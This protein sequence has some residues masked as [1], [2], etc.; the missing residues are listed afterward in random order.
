[1]A[2]VTFTLAIFYTVAAIPC[3]ASDKVL[4]AEPPSSLGL[5]NLSFFR[6]LGLDAAMGDALLEAALAM[7]VFAAA[8][9]VMNSYRKRN[10][11]NTRAKGKVASNEPLTPDKL[12][13]RSTRAVPHS[14]TESVQEDAQPSPVRPAPKPCSVD[15]KSMKPLQREADALATAVRQGKVTQLPQLLDSAIDR[16]FGF[17]ARQDSP[18]SK[19]EL[20]TALLHASLR[21]CAANRLFKEGIATYEHVGQRIGEGSSGLWS[22]LLYCI[23]EAGSFSR[24]KDVFSKLSKF[25]TPSDHDFVNMVRC[26]IGLQ[27]AQGLEDMLITLREANQ[28]V[29]T[30]TW[31]R[32]LAACGN[33]EAALDLAEVLMR[34]RICCEDM[35][36]VG[37]NTLIKYNAR[38]GN[39]SRC[40]ELQGEMKTK[41][42]EA[43]E[44]TFGLLLDA[45][46]AGK[47][48]ECAKRVFDE[49]CASGLRLNV[50]HCTTFLKTLLSAGKL[51]EAAAVLKE[52]SVSAGVRPD[53]IS[54]STVVKAYADTGD[55]KSALRILQDMLEAGVRPDEI[56][57]NS[58]L[59]GCSIFPIKSAAVMQTFEKLVELGMRPSTTTLSILLKCL[60]HTQDWSTSLQVLDTCPKRFR[61]EAETRL[62]IQ[63][64]QACIKDRA[65][66]EAKE[67][68]EALL[69]AAA[70]RHEQIDPAMVGRLLRACAL[71]GDQQLAASI[72]D[73]AC[74]AGIADTGFQSSRPA[75]AANT[76]MSP[77]RRSRMPSRR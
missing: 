41:G 47:Q 39:T 9:A 57:F 24:C 74:R 23:T 34:S 12:K 61:L 70:R 72:K 68:F 53:L 67:V 35:D 10:P 22:V 48:L 36:A 69:A 42:V 14:R 8:S 76:L 44:I 27:D 63:L 65:S 45:C 3:Q 18:A 13:T 66:K 15:A 59:T 62:F 31:N 38:A 5:L 71:S 1:M 64:A 21:A 49:L 20:T 50:V 25:G 7:A 46:V 56:I 40:F 77:E 54:Y 51:D 75:S 26:Y 55:V 73:A 2:S 43:S 60:A 6:D 32:A 58:V 28:L 4:V 19:E 37:F 33:S 29:N 52:M 30:Y 17:A 16:A 11:K